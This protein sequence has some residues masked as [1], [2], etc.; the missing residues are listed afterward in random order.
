MH[1]SDN[2]GGDGDGDGDD[3]DDDD[4][5]HDNNH[6]YNTNNYNEHENTFIH[7]TL[8]RARLLSF[9]D[10]SS[11]S[12]ISLPAASVIFTLL[13]LADPASLAPCLTVMS[14]L[15][16]AAARNDLTLETNNFSGDLRFHSPTNANTA[17]Y[18]HFP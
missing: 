3:D 9:P 17:S 18:N 1:V 10:T 16:R 13:L 12:S 11:S 7:S 14:H 15:L 8:L 2:Y 4:D 5:D 6:N